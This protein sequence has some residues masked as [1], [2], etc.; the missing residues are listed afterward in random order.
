LNNSTKVKEI[1]IRRLFQTAR[2]LFPNADCEL[3]FINVYELSVAVILSAQTTDPSVNK[4]TPAVFKAFPDVEHLAQAELVTLE[5]MIKTLG[6]YHS[7]AKHLIDFARG[8]VDKYEGQVPSDFV[9]LQTLPGIGRKT[10]N[11][12]IS[13]GFNLPGL[14]V[15]T[16][17]LRVSQ[18]FGIVKKDANPTQVEMTLKNALNESE[19]GEAHHALLF[20]GRYHCM[21]RNPKC[22]SCPL[23]LE[24]R[25]KK[26]NP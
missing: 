9:Q 20:F 5:N 2:T 26:M 3:N 19:W 16:H 12:I 8:V 7:K 13:V 24:C 4:V 23:K 15:D 10:A 6:L 14:A 11:V 21:A 18:R 25:Y 1:Q 22:E 17:V